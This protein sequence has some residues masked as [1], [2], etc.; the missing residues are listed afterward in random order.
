VGLFC[1]MLVRRASEVQRF[2]QD[3][4]TNSRRLKAIWCGIERIHG[5]RLCLGC[6]VNSVTRDR[7]GG[8]AH[9]LAVST[10]R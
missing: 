10:V 8:Y 9:F 5:A 2:H 6:H 7:I 3:A 1:G 4:E